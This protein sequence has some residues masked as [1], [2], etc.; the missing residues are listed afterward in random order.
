MQFEVQPEGTR[1]TGA[2]VELGGSGRVGAST[3]KFADT[4]PLFPFIL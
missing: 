4:L 2:I 3:L 1:L